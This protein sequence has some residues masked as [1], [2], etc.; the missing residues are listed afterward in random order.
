MILHGAVKYKNDVLRSCLNYKTAY[1]I[2]IVVI[3]ARSAYF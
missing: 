1:K 3:K 2:D